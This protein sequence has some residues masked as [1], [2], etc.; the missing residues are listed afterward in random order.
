MTRFFEK[1][2][3]IKPW[4]ILARG[5]GLALDST[6]KN[7]G[8]A[9]TVLWAAADFL[10]IYD[11]DAAF[12]KLDKQSREGL[13]KVEVRFDAKKAEFEDRLVAL[14]EQKRFSGFSIGASVLLA[15]FAIVSSCLHDYEKQEDSWLL[16]LRV[17]NAL[18]FVISNLAKFYYVDDYD[19]LLDEMDVLASRPALTEI[20]NSHDH[21]SDNAEDNE[22]QEQNSENE[23]N[24]AV[25]GDGYSS[26]ASFGR[27]G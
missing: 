16:C 20:N 1:A 27:K 15:T 25:D 13:D 2:K 8:I 18:S 24:P 14:T 19:V 10:S 4:S 9:G 3:K 17:C 5:A 26:S 11:A 7:Q 22:E 6:K 23:E 12:K 21:T